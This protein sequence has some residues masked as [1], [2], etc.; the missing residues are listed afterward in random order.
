[1]FSLVVKTQQQSR[2]RNLKITNTKPFITKP[3]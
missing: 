1:M 3:H 2:T